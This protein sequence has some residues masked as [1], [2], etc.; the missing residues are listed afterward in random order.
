MVFGPA[1]NT[2]EVSVGRVEGRLWCRHRGGEDFPAGVDRLLGRGQRGLGR[3]TSASE[4]PYHPWT[5]RPRACPRPSIQLTASLTDQSQPTALI[6][7]ARDQALS[8]QWRPATTG[9][10][11]RDPPTPS[12]GAFD[13]T[14]RELLGA[15]K[16]S[17]SMPRH[18]SLRCP[19]TCAGRWPRC[20]D[21]ELHTASHVTSPTMSRTEGLAPDALL[22]TY[23]A[24]I[25]PGT[26]CT[27]RGVTIVIFAF[28][29]FDIDPTW[30]SSPPC[31]TYRRSSPP[32]V[33]ARIGRGDPRAE[34]SMDLQVAHAIAPDARKVV[35]NARPTP[36][37][38]TAAIARW[39]LLEGAATRSAAFPAP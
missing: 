18:T 9:W 5:H 12:S 14:V 32:R 28:D 2:S 34:L 26:D 21:P 23:N 7:W 30:T 22:N 31:S 10:S 29:G 39:P 16:A 35:V 8:V 4:G 33:V 6:D 38:V 24:T 3:R 20:A 13:V 11:S 36:S 1:P 37:K 15:A 27:G 25:W 17:T 19:S